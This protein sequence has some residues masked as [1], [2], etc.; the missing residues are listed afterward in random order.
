MSIPYEPVRRVHMRDCKHQTADEYYR[1][2][3][4]WTRFLVGCVVVAVCATALVWLLV[5]AA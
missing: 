3:D 2:V 4:S 5:R 1:R